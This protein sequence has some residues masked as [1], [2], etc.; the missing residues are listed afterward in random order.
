[1]KKVVITG[2]N[3]QDGT[4]LARH[5]SLQGYEIIGITSKY[6]DVNKRFKQINLNPVHTSNFRERLFHL[7][8]CT[9]PAFLYHLASLNK[10]SSEKSAY[11]H[12]DLDTVNI[13]YT[14]HLLSAISKVSPDTHVF[15]AGSSQQFTPPITQHVKANDLQS[16]S[17]YYAVTKSVNQQQAHR[18]RRKGLSITFAI[19]FNHDSWARKSNFLLPSIASKLARYSISSNENSGCINLTLQNPNAG[20]DLCSARRCVRIFSKLCEAGYNTDTTVGSGLTTSI[21]N[22][23]SAME[24]ITDL[25]IRLSAPLPA[26]SQPL[27]PAQQP[28]HPLA[29]NEFLLDYPELYNDFNLHY[30]VKEIYGYHRS[31]Q[32]KKL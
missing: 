17:N 13:H 32:M 19:L 27:A 25:K 28:P 20:F 1:M 14:E 2:I 18:Y 22:I 6:S 9:R 31:I 29:S 23:L 3:G 7:L 30:L 4:L 24:K 16:P 5:L 26:A 10:P 21:H 12:L 8:D 11:R 15:M